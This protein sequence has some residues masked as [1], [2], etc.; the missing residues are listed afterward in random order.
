MLAIYLLTLG[1]SAG[2]VGVFFR[3]LLAEA[4]YI[5]EFQAGVAV[6][7][8]AASTYIA[9]QL[10]FM[11]VIRL[12]WPT[13]SHAPILADCVSH[14]AALVLL[15]P[16]MGVTI[17]WPHPALD[18]F[19]PLLFLG[20]FVGL[21]TV[22]KLFTFYAILHSETGPRYGS[23]FW[24]A[25]VGLF[26]LGAYIPFTWWLDS[27][28]HFQPQ[29]MGTAEAYE[30]DGAYSMARAL[31][32]GSVI[33]IE[34]PGT[35]GAGLTVRWAPLAEESDDEPLPGVFAT[36]SMKGNENKDYSAWV[37]FEESGWTVMQVPPHEVPDGLTRC[38][39]T[40]YQE[41]EP[42]W[43]SV[44]G[45]RPII[46]DGRRVMVSGPYVHL[47]AD[48]PQTGSSYVVLVVDG[49]GTDRVS[50]LGDRKDVT[51]F[52]DHLGQTAVVFPNAY[53]PAPDPSAA[54]MTL[55]TGTS[56]LRH[57]YLGKHQGPLPAD[58]PT[59]AEALG[60]AHFTTAAFT[61]ADARPDF[62][63]GSGFERGFEQYDVA[64]SP[65][66]EDAADDA[67]DT[68][69]KVAGSA[70][71][72]KRALRWIA[73][74]QQSRFLVVISLTEL[75]DMTYRER[76]GDLKTSGKASPS[77][78]AIYDAGLRYLDEQIGE[79]VR[80][81]R[82]TDQGD[83]TCLLITAT[84]GADFTPPPKLTESVL[85]IPIWIA[86]PGVDPVVRRDLAALEEVAPTLGAMAGI[87][88][89]GGRSL[90][91]NPVSVEPTS[92]AGDPIVLTLR[93]DRWR[94]YWSSQ[95]SPFDGTGTASAP[96]AAL[97]DLTLLPA[98]KTPEDVATTHPE[99][100]D[101]W[102]K[103]LDAYLTEESQTWRSPSPN[104][105]N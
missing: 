78:D 52:L 97:Y 74:N 20:A 42:K 80:E 50:A 41:Q 18:K 49:L 83:N 27:L 2:I 44:L 70:A 14:L 94:L 58:C 47:A 56:P 57:G 12:I 86:A 65:G 90:I 22:L 88:F 68:P 95:R 63:Y 105:S 75:R 54:I 34:V 82:G 84:H 92:M 100:V 59:L 77:P 25:A 4:G 60:D 32:E 37:P 9:T 33:D 89:A 1:V 15:P 104:E 85:R 101:R 19:T 55:L 16:L 91:D 67:E 17:A 5:P 38:I 6:A 79:F 21:H 23:L 11:T 7:C 102:S 69:A 61:E 96:N 71:T 40:W 103:R 28:R 3:T 93:N 13:R 48:N 51:P 62:A 43:R 87:S 98:G 39:V 76:Y 45:I 66:D 99:I 35:S 10:L 53:T 30:F 46:S 8:G 29:A 64:Y 36:V 72:L 73:R 24:V 81:L 31:P 26:C